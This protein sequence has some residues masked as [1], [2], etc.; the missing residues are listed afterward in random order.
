VR[1][2]IKKILILPFFVVR[3]AAILIEK[4]TARTQRHEEKLVTQIAGAIGGDSGLIFT[5]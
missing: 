1:K 2:G 5:P 3:V 4:F